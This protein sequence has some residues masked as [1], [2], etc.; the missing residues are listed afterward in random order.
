VIDQFVGDEDGLEICRAIRERAPSVAV[1]MTSGS[2]TLTPQMARAAGASGLVAKDGAPAELHAAIR[3]V[4]V[5]GTRPER[6][7]GRLSRRQ[8]EIL[9]LMGRGA[10]NAR[11]AD[12]LGLSV[13]AMEQYAAALYRRLGV[14][15]RAAAVHLAASQ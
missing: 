1:L 15:S 6:A 4:A 14:P 7:P 5:A 9:D 8:Q 10:T 12:L 11:I 13:A 2:A 3:S